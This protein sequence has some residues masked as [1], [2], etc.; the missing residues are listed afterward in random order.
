MPPTFAIGDIGVYIILF[1]AMYFE[2]FLF[3]SFL[4]HRPK[5]KTARRPKYYPSVTIIVP[6][7]NEETT[8]AGTI[9]SLLAMEYPREKLSIMVVDDGSL[10]STLAVANTF[11]N[12]PQVE[13][14]HKKNGGK[15]T[16]LNLG[17]ERSQADIVGCLDADSFVAPDALIESIKRF[18]EDAQIMAV[19]PAMKVQSPHN[20]LELMQAV[21]Y[22]FGIFYK[23]MFDNLAAISVLP[24]P[25]SLYR[26]EVF[27]KVG[28][29]RHAHNTE[30]MEMAWRMHAHHLAIANA[31]TAVVYTKVPSTI[32]ALLKQRTRWSQ[33]FLDNSKDYRHMYFNARFGNFGLL[34]LPFGLTMFLGSLYVWGYM[35][36]N[37]ISSVV[38]RALLMWSSQV[39]MHLPKLSFHFDWF[40]VDTG[41][42]SSL[43]I[44]CLCATLAA[45]LIGRRIAGANFGLG[46]IAA[47]FTLYGFL[48]PIWLARAAW[49]SLRSKES[50]WRENGVH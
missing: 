4:K 35:I 45:I 43:G 1:L 9:E 14:I 36:W 7:F 15:Y 16:A 46:S 17:I 40:Y 31:H 25:F 8:L 6:C 32:R 5:E 44:L 41:L 29:F 23:K 22:T 49:A 33:G 12:N 42:L 28:L 37:A 19:V 11:S 2:V 18:E 47:Y 10:D 27:A 3:I 20:L 26:R 24:G 38:H 34:I 21:E 39:P 48:A 30:D 13:V 50:V